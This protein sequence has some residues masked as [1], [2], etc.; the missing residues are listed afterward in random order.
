MPPTHAGPP[1]KTT[2]CGCLVYRT[3]QSGP[4]IL[5]IKPWLNKNVWGLPKGHS[6]EGETNLDCA[7][8]ETFEETGV[9]ALA[10]DELPTCFCSSF[11][12]EKT[13]HTFFA[14][15][16][17]PNFV[18][19]ARD[20]ENAEVAFWPIDRLPR[21]TAYQASTILAALASVRQRLAERA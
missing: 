9:V 6:E 5:L 1:R 15:P 13:V 19:Y 7:L 4:E 8:R 2:S 20:G 17:D 12:E 11:G 10:E 16:V 18:P 3:G 21:L 14:R